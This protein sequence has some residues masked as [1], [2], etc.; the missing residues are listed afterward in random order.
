MDTECNHGSAKITKIEGGKV[1]AVCNDCK[2]SLQKDFDKFDKMSLLYMFSEDVCED[3]EHNGDCWDGGCG[4]MPN[5][6]FMRFYCN[7]GAHLCFGDFE[8]NIVQ[9]TAIIELERR[10]KQSQYNLINR[11]GD[12]NCAQ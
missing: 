11:D 2:H 12:L 4:I 3:C 5:P 10:K 6:N 9:Q 1:E 7:K 8:L